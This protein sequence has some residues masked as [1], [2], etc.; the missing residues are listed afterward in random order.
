LFLVEEMPGKPATQLKILFSPLDWGLGHAARLIPLIQTYKTRGHKIILGGNGNSLQM[1]KNEFPELETVNIPFTE[2]RYGKGQIQIFNFLAGIFRL[3]FAFRKEHRVLNSIIRD[4]QIDLV[5]SDNRLGLFSKNAKCIVITHQ[6]WLQMPKG[7]SLLE[8]L[9]NQFNHYFIRK[10][11]ECWVVDSDKTPHLAGELSHPPLMESIVRYIGPVSRF[12]GKKIES[13]K[14][15]EILVI[16]GG[17]EPQRTILEEILMG[18]ISRAR[19]KA[20]I[21][22]G[23]FKSNETDILPNISYLPYADSKQLAELIQS[24][25]IIICRSGYSSVMD[26]AAL[27]HSAILIPTPG[28]PEQEYLAE[29]LANKRY[30]LSYTQSEFDLDKAV[31]AWK[32]FKHQIPQ[33]KFNQ[34]PH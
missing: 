8:L 15:I 33:I 14:K 19:F 32:T 4:K 34:F 17:P 24:A 9:A 21:A 23:T 31:E 29:Y 18:Q 5:I 1:L 16:L 6:I 28:Q 12:A 30:F 10:F 3:F 27:E 22:G 2:I 11:A 25:D 20:V 26:L 13:L 7:W